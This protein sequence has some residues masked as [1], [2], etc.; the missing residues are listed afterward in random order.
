MDNLVKK[1]P[2]ES[3]SIEV[4]SRMTREWIEIGPRLTRE[5]TD[6]DLAEKCQSANSAIAKNE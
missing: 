1:E 2:K 4:D 3:L 5:R 6:K